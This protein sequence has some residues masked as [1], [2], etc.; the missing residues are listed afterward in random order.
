[1]PFIIVP[2]FRSCV[3]Q[4][5]GSVGSIGVI[6][7]VIQ[8]TYSM[9]AA[10]AGNWAVDIKHIGAGGVN[11]ASSSGGRAACGRDIR[12]SRIINSNRE[13]ADRWAILSRS[14][15]TDTTNRASACVYSLMGFI[16]TG[17]ASC[18]VSDITSKFIPRSAGSI[19]VARG[20]RITGSEVAGTYIILMG[21]LCIVF[22]VEMNAPRDVGNV[23]RARDP[24]SPSVSF[25]GSI[26]IARG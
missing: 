21:R 18:V 3:V 17:T 2:L 11:R 4:I 24:R 10:A 23:G 26:L 25:Q 16:E 8:S 7:W 20:T 1:M 5:V 6:A 9:D 14:G 15:R 12:S 13:M 22:E 19:V